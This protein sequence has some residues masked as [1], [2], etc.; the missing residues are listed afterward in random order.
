MKINIILLV[1]LSFTFFISSKTFAEDNPDISSEAAILMDSKSGQVLYE[2]NANKKMYPA[3]LSK[4]ATAIYA[5]EKGNLDDLVTVSKEAHQV[6]GTRVYLEEGEKVPLKK[7]IQGLLINSGN[8]A[9]VAIAEHL[10]GSVENFSLNINNYL[11]KL[12]VNHTNFQNPHGL[13]DPSHVTTANDLAVITRYAMRNK[14][15]R[16][17]FATR[18]LRW[19]GESWQ[20]TL[21]THHK[22]MREQPY[23][24][25]TGGKTGYVD[26]SGHTLATT[27]KKD[28]LSLIVVILNGSTQEMA[29]KDTTEL[30]DYGFRHYETSLIPKGTKYSN[31]NNQFFVAEDFYFTKSLNQS[32]ETNINEKGLLEILQNQTAIAS[33]QLENSK[34]NLTKQAGAT[35][36][37]LPV[38]IKKYFN[39]ILIIVLI[40]FF[41]SRF[42]RKRKSRRKKYIKTG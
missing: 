39:G 8:D 32:V 25:V 4:I 30:L 24:G 29:Y 36:N 15:F 17:I 9:G 20:T 34:S 2:K 23:E 38:T 22:L 42:K 7:L 27:A 31:K 10:D 11:N 5:L 28:G 35:G 6:E 37:G 14:E 21:I 12:G 3:S 13:F 16:E 18:E 41:G 19:K 26:Q 1:V 40:V 33:A